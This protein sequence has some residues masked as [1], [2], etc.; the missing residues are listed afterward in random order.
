M[1]REGGIIKM[2]PIVMGFAMLP[3]AIAAP[4]DGEP[5][6]GDPSGQNEAPETVIDVD[7]NTYHT[8]TIGN[9]VWTAENLRVARYRDGTPIPG[10]PESEEW[11][12][13][14]TG[15]YCLPEHEPSAQGDRYGLLY[16]FHA[17]QDRRGLCPAGWHVPTADE[18]RTLVD[19]LGGTEVAGGRM[20]ET[21]SGL[22]RVSV[23]GTTNESGFSAVPAGGRGRFGEAAE[24]G[25][26]ATWWSSTPAE[27]S[28]AW[29][30]GLY[31][32]RN[33]IRFNPGDQTSGFSVRCIRD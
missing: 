31:P 29:H 12:G 23:P 4:G 33:G 28:S 2:I 26:Y 5:R 18:W 15:A 20:K 3:V 19:C 7:G 9:Q 11:S 8:V 14:T 10:V 32:D 17:T 13:L 24:V 25:Y 1:N 21:S 6:H 27:A 16:N 22:W 30:W